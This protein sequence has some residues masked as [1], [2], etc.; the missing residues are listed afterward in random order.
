[1]GIKINIK[2]VYLNI[3]RNDSFKVAQEILRRHKVKHS[4]FEVWD[5]LS[6]ILN[7]VKEMKHDRLEKFQLPSK[8]KS[9][10]YTLGKGAY[11]YDD[12][13]RARNHCKGR[14]VI[15]TKLKN[16]TLTFH[17]QKNIEKILDFLENDFQLF[18]E[19][20]FADDKPFKDAYMHIKT[21]MEIEAYESFSKNPHIA[22][23]IIDIMCF[24]KKFENTDVYLCDIPKQY[25]VDIPEEVTEVVVKNDAVYEQNSF[26]LV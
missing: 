20:N 26:A 7:R 4:P 16:N 1:M 25:Q 18:I 2:V 11:F 24:F 21:L 19:K 15:K 22:G 8:G 3:Y 13:E 23:I 9:Y 14:A 5:Y 17:I 6:D 12:L 10:V